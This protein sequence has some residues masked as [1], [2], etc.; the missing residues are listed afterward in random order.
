M[1]NGWHAL[2]LLVVKLGATALCLGSGLVGGTF[3]PSLFLGAVLGVACCAAAGP[4][5]DAAATAL[6]A[7][8]GSSLAG[9]LPHLTSADSPAF[10]MIGAA[11]TLAAVFRAPLTASLLLFELTRGYE[12]VVPVLAAAGTGAF[13]TI[14]LDDA[15]QRAEA[16]RAAAAGDVDN[17]MVSCAETAVS[18]PTTGPHELTSSSASRAEAERAPVHITT[19]LRLVYDGPV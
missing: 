9:A 6:P 7:G 18:A 15:R 3:A 14:A 5:L 2:A 17:L 16:A 12:L 8:L 19:E 1:L 11:A 10:A 13:V 4:T